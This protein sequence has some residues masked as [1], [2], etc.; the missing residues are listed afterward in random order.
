MKIILA[1][2]KG[3]SQVGPIL[4]GNLQFNFDP[5]LLTGDGANTERR[6]L[7]VLLF[8]PEKMAEVLKS[9]NENTEIIFRIIHRF[10][11]KNLIPESAINAIGNLTKREIEMLEHL[12]MGLTQ[13]QIAERL[14]IALNTVKSHF[15]KIFDTVGLHNSICALLAYLNHMGR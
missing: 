9:G 10:T 8:T 6:Y 5:S 15:G 13:E 3:S 1:N 12:C 2:Q 14:C 4:T 7:N 11:D